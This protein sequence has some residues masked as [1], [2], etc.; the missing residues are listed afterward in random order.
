MP[1]SYASYMNRKKGKVFGMGNELQKQDAL[2]KLLMQQRAKQDIAEVMTC[3]ERSGHFG[4]SLSQ[5]EATQLLECR[6]KSLETYQRI[7]LSQTMLPKLIEYFCDSD[8]INQG[9]Y[10]ETLEALLGIFYEFKQESLDLLTDDELLTFMRE[11]YDEICFGDLEY[12][13]GTCLERFAEAIKGGYRGYQT[14]G[15]AGE[16]QQLSTEMRWD[17]ELYQ[18]VLREL[19][20]R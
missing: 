4:L 15:G 16:Y 19:F 11:Q 17:R 6:N 7:E 2:M 13:E 8:Y 1:F 3:N 9:D 12:L 10:L 18:E 20:W 5:E 14:T